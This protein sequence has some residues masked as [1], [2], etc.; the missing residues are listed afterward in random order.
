MKRLIRFLQ[1]PLASRKQH[2]IILTSIVLTTGLAT[3]IFFTAAKQIGS[4][5]TEYQSTADFDNLIT[6]PNQE[7]IDIEIGNAVDQSPLTPDIGLP[8]WDGTSR[9]TVLVMGL[10][11]RD[12]FTGDGP[13]RTDTMM[14]LTLD[15]LNNTAGMLSIPRD[16]WVAIPGFENGRINTAYF[17]GETYNLP[18]GGP[19]L[20]VKTVYQLL[21]VPIH[22]SA[23]VDF[24]AFVQFVDEIE[25]IKID[26]PEKI[27][28]DPIVGDPVILKAERQTL[29]GELALAYARAR[30]SE[31]GDLD[32]AQR[33]QLVILGIRERLLSPDALA[34]LIFKAPTLYE[35]LISGIKTNLQLE[36]V[37]R[38]TALAQNIPDGNIEREAIDLNQVLLAETPD[39]QKILI[40]LPDKIR[41]L[42]DEI[43]L[44][45]TGTL[46]PLAPGSAQERM[47][48]EGANIRLLNSSQVE[49]LALRTQGYL[50]AQGATI[51]E[52][53]TGEYSSTTQIV[54]YT[55][56]PHTTRYLIELFGIAP[57]YYALNFDPQSAVDISL[58][59]GTDWAQNN[60]MP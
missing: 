13:P 38:L 52:V 33:Q 51:I 17:L 20:A 40:P 39:G 56:N 21:G 44:T 1:S 18:G 53:A 5:G 43:F 12:W 47:T 55:G 30:N 2:M 41:Q 42:R 23:Q 7:P 24:A 19:A 45:N 4:L 46:G 25:G 34:T 27:K 58:I 32:R 26:V 50:Q 6:L 10:D 8:V 37:I 57:G 60:P 16:L 35:Q 14:L 49:V 22:Y 9:V 59:L 28:I 11:Y 36:Q 15:P 48:A 31:A 54:D 3:A 29:F